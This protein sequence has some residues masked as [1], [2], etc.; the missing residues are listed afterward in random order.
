MS[1]GNRN[2]CSLSTFGV[3]HDYCRSI[4]IAVYKRPYSLNQYR[5][6]NRSAPSFPRPQTCS[7]PKNFF[8]IVGQI[9]FLM[10]VVNL[11]FS[12][13]LYSIFIRVLKKK[14]NKVIYLLFKTFLITFFKRLLSTDVSV[15]KGGGGV[16]KIMSY[17]AG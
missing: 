12:F 13:P 11:F 8:L 9:L 2:V 14:E 10:L 17:C 3:S 1:P 16:T 4:T 5:L 15:A 7:R 6:L